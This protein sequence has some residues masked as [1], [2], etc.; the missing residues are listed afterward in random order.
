MEN[1]LIV[2]KGSEKYAQLAA[3][4]QWNKLSEEGIY[5]RHLVIVSK[6]KNKVPTVATEEHFLLLEFGFLLKI[7][8]ELILFSFNYESWKRQYTE[9]ARRKAV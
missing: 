5:K 8:H 6:S 9:D 1:T 4:L 3:P 2:Y 7:Q